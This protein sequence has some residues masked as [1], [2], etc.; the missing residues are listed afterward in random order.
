MKQEKKTY[1]DGP[2]EGCHL[3]DLTHFEDN[4]IVIGY[5]PFN[6]NYH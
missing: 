3:L 5:K 1:I 2:K 6:Q 4:N